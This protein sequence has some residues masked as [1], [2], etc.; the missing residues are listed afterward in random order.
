VEGPFVDGEQHGRWVFRWADG[1][2]WNEETY[3]NGKLQ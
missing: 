2:V 3:V 1:T